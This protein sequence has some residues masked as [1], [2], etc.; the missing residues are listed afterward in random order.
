MR[1]LF[2]N[3]AAR[4]YIVGQSLSSLGDAS[5]WLAAAIWVR[6]LTGS[7]ADA[8]LVMFFFGL[9][10]FGGPLVGM[11]V[12]RMRRL[13]LII[14]ANLAGCALVAPLLL[15]HGRGAVPVVYA[16]MTGYGLLNRLISAAQSA[17]LTTVVKERD[18][19]SANS[20]L[21][22]MQESMRIVVPLLG[23]GLFVWKGMASVVVLDL[24]T[25]AGAVVIFS[26]LRVAEERPAPAETHL[27][28]ELTAGARHVV[29]RPALRAVVLG[30]TVAAMV[31]GFTES[32]LFAVV[33]QGLHRPAAFVGVTGV[34]Q[35]V[36]SIAVA[37]FAGRLN[38]RIGELWMVITGLLVYALSLLLLIAATLLSVLTGLFLA[39]IAFPLLIVGAITC[40]QRHT[41]DNLQG[42]VYAF[43]EMLSD[44]A[45]ISSI[46]LGAGLLAVLGFR[47]LLV[48]AVCVIVIACLIVFSG[49]RDA[50]PPVDGNSAVAHLEKSPAA[51]I[52][53]VES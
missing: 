33:T 10:A 24:A 27:W 12:D 36:G 40:L 1:S 38:N 16:V 22:S 47:P 30:V 17:L 25:F 35:G 20:V 13:P 19:G 44:T 32:A 14:G 43:Y 4:L 23:A 51:N 28:R 45:M 21:R 8:G 41:P 48:A 5:L 34:A 37:P 11:V 42:R 18:L 39:G 26:S 15:V 49:R 31:F 3:R 52:V 6:T 2:R 7:S 50:L 29:A 9:S 53:E 46:A